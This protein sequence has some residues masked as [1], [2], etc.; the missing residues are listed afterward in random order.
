[1]KWVSITTDTDNDFYQFWKTKME[2]Q[3]HSYSAIQYRLTIQTIEDYYHH[4]ILC[5]AVQQTLDI[6]CDSA[7]G[8]IKYRYKAETPVLS[9]TPSSK[10]TDKME[11][12]TAL[13]IIDSVPS[14][15]D[16]NILPDP[17]EPNSIKI[18]I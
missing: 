9:G 6:Q 10:N 12:S 7:S 2:K 8:K 15:S 18:A 4:V 5:P 14:S 11:G 16:Q 17:V 1:M 3:D 13:A